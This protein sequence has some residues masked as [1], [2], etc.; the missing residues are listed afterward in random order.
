[1]IPLTEADLNQYLAHL[2]ASRIRYRAE[3]IKTGDEYAKRH[4]RMLDEMVVEALGRTKF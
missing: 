4:L 3:L 1:M 2:E